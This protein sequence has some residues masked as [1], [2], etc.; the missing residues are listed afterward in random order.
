MFLIHRSKGVIEIE[1]R[2]TSGRRTVL[3]R[4]SNM[5]RL[6]LDLFYR[7]FSHVEPAIASTGTDGVASCTTAVNVFEFR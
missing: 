5:E 2:G 3:E 7:E 4:R 6:P 1:L